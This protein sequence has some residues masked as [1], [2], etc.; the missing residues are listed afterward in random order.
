[1]K[2]NLLFLSFYILL[3]TSAV[4]AQSQTLT[5]DEAIQIALENNTDIK[6]SKMS[7]DK[8]RAAVREAFGYALPSLDLSADFSH[9]LK[10]PK[11]PF[12]DFEALLTNATYSIL[13]DENVIPRDDS[14]YV[15]VETTLQSFALN[16]AYTAS[17]TL[18][19]VL[20][21]SA[22]FRGIGASQIY[23]DLSLAELRNTISKTKLDVERAFYGTL[24]T[25]ELLSITEAS[26]KNAQENFRNVNA[27]FEQGFVSDF[28]RLQAEV[29]V[30]NIRPV[31]LQMENMLA[32]TLNDLKLVLGVDQS[33]EIDV[34]GE[35]VYNP[36]ILPGE[37]D[38]IDYALTNNF[39]LQSMKL[40]MNLDEE[41]IQLDVSEY[42]PSL[43]AFGNFMYAG[44]SDEWNFQNYNATTVGLSLS[45]NLW[46]GNR[47]KNRVEQSTISYKQTSEQYGLLQEYVVNQVKAKYL[48]L[49]RVQSLVEA[50]QKN[51]SLAER[52]YELST[53]RYKEGTG[54]QL[55]VQNSDVALRQ[56]RINKLQS[57]HSYIVTKYELEQLMGKINQEYI[58]PYMPKE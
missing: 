42:W 43:A 27:L 38:I 18:T 15:P 4:N 24:L 3:I 41:F 40:K 2:K 35:I 53:V 31:L 28:D 17:L 6:V 30:E 7:T 39:G 57:V 16:N 8:S 10:K 11:M 37:D 9:F 5:L 46:Q 55:E 50:Q 19:Q 13:F 21:N 34:K 49:K 25:K 22:V 44:S 23:Y 54:S 58:D 20:F 47:T 36:E 12:P 33:I 48:E 52:A 56:A 45:M 29:R 1:M 51:V 14:K 32:T 26:Y